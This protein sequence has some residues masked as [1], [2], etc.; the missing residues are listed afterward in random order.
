MKE[1]DKD[2]IIGILARHLG[3]E[4]L[5]SRICEI[6][7]EVYNKLAVVNESDVI[8]F[9]MPS[10]RDFYHRRKKL[11]LSMQDVTNCTGVS[12]ATISRLEKGKEV[13]YSNVESIHKFYLSNEA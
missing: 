2:T 1:T 13:Y 11:G 9:V 6:G 8:D 12:K 5:N 4:V 3:N 7:E 10:W